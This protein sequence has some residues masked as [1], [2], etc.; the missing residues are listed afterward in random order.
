MD[1]TFDELKSV[2]WCDVRLVKMNIH[3]SASRCGRVAE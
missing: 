2:V 1:T 3:I